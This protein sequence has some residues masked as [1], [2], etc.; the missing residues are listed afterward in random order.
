[1]FLVSGQSKRKAVA[2]WRAGKPIPARA[3]MP[4]AGVDVLV[5]SALLE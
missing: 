3:I 1:V 2:A 4:E 5:E